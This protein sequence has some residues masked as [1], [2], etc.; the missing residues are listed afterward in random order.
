M[1]QVVPTIKNATIEYF[2]SEAKNAIDNLGVDLSSKVTM[3]MVTG[4]TTY[5]DRQGVMEAPTE[6]ATSA[7]PAVPLT[8]TGIADFAE[9]ETLLAQ[10]KGRFR[11]RTLIS[12]KTQKT[13]NWWETEDEFLTNLEQGRT[14]PDLI[15]TL[16]NQRTKNIIA[17]LSAASVARID[18][19]GDPSTDVLPDSQKV[20]IDHGAAPAVGSLTMDYDGI[21]S[22]VSKFDQAGASG[23]ICCL[24]T[25]ANRD[26][27]MQDDRFANNDYAKFVDYGRLD[28]HTLTDTERITFIVV[29]STTYTQVRTNLNQGALLADTL[30]LF[31]CKEAIAGGEF[32][33]GQYNVDTAIALENRTIVSM[34]E[35]YNSVRID[36]AGVVQATVQ[37]TAA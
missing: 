10:N 31:W 17:A 27:L 19:A 1:A 23:E 14:V 4:T 21:Q 22:I 11:I 35:F 36:D 20:V 5:I 28:K 15:R 26:L 6:I 18:T 37:A 24:L 2:Q 12:S 13:G 9:Y 7:Q 16:R 30:M 25:P 29:P 3:E 34:K 32:Y 8:S 33:P